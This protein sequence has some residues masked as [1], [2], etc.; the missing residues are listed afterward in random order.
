MDDKEMMTSLSKAKGL[1]LS[2]VD[3][4]VATGNLTKDSLCLMKEAMEVI[5]KIAHIERGQDPDG[6]S[7]KNYYI[8]SWDYPEGD[9]YYQD[10]GNSYMRGRDSRSGR[11]MSRDNN[12]NSG[13]SYTGGDREYMIRNLEMA[14]DEAGNEQER[15]QIRNLINQMKS[16]RM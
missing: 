16:G 3:K 5:E 15:M 4:I 8:R 9:N 7:Q 6:Y 2:E 12:P 11:Y 13:M 1:V 10:N 14:M